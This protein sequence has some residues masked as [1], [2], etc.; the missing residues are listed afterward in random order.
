MLDFGKTD[1]RSI[2]SFSALAPQWKLAS[3]ALC[4]GLMQLAEVA[5]ASTM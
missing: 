5:E 4:M 1:V 2:Q 3:M